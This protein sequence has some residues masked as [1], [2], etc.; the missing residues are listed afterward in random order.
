MAE[1]HVEREVKLDVESDF[2]VPDICDALTVPARVEVVDEQLESRYFDTES[3]DLLNAHMTLR[4]RLG[5]ADC[6]WQLKVPHPPAREEIR[7]GEG[8]EDVPA[9][10]HELLLG[11]TRGAPLLPL[12]MITTERTVHRVIG[13]DGEVLAEIADDRVHAVSLGDAGEASTWR[14]VEVELGGGDE[15]LSKAI[16]KRLRK[17][18]AWRASTASKLARALDAHQGDGDIASEVAGGAASEAADAVLAYM[19]EQQRAILAG[20]VASRRDKDEAVHETRVA[21]R[22]MRSVLRSYAKLFQPGSTEA[23]D[24]SLRWYAGL[25]GQVRDRQVLRRRLSQRIDELPPELVLGP[26]RE[27]VE[28]EL[29]REQAEH[30]SA[31]RRELTEARYLELL[32]A[33]ANW[34]AAPAW[35]PNAD[36]PLSYLAKL[37]RRTERKAAQRLAAA[38][39]SG[40]VEELHRARKAAKRARY[41]YEVLEPVTQ[42]NGARKK[43]KRQRALQDLIGEHQDSHLSAETIRRLGVSPGASSGAETAFIFGMLYERERELAR[44]ARSSATKR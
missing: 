31:L 39:E 23:L 27:R 30:W 10:L 34:L 38:N 41:A 15:A 7:V 24:E 6:G 14:E 13:D 11:V 36:K 40:D 1:T 3:H 25:L 2:V 29:G 22:R 9:E 18:G 26:V 33:L 43:A 16:V 42:G 32:A 4:R 17:A 37:A 8:G 44:A 35:S 21:V 12:A 19:L 5:T 28:S 20:D